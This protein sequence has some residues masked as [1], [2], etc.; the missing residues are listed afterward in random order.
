ML[1]LLQ[2]DLDVDDLDVRD[3]ADQVAAARRQ[4]ERLRTL[5]AEL[6][7]ISRLDAGLELRTEPVELEEIAR[8][9]AAE[10]ELR[11]R[12]LD[13]SLSVKPPRGPCWA[14]G[15]PDA[16]ARIVRILLDNALRY[17]PAGTTITTTIS[18]VG[19]TAT[20]SVH[21]DGPGVPPA[22]RE[23]IFDRFHRGS[24]AGSD[25]GFGL[26]LAIGR[27]LAIKQHG[28]LLLD[29]EASGAT[30]VLR[31]PIGMPIGSHDQTESESSA[32]H[33]GHA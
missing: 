2:E 5:A 33:R 24:E 31:L 12:P 7:D 16:T 8:A 15:D 3:A 26:G 17:G 10:F 30:F 6:L 23:H 9:V 27:E 11:A 1:E 25:G 14:L 32:P 18:Y 29:A 22:E 20:L 4:V 28:E 21:D 19:D 13:V